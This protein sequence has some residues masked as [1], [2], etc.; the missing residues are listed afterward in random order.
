MTPCKVTCDAHGVACGILLGANLPGF[1]T[2]KTE[3]DHEHN[4]L[5]VKD[6]A[7]HLILM[8]RFGSRG[9]KYMRRDPASGQLTEVSKTAFDAAVKEVRKGRTHKQNEAHEQLTKEL[10]KLLGAHV[11]PRGNMTKKWR[12]DKL[13][14][15]QGLDSWG[16]K[17]LVAWWRERNKTI[18]Q[19][20]EA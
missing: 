14:E 20:K 18:T 9:D 15:A 4:C 7:G 5:P 12:D 6:V 13:Q 11:A 8:H 17:H 2:A 1:N 10:H 16:L 19:K 3:A